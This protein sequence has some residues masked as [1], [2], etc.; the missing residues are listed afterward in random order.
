MPFDWWHADTA[1]YRA[2]WKTMADIRD[3][4]MASQIMHVFDSLSTSGSVRKKALVIVNYRHAFGHR[5]ESPVGKKPNNTGR[6]LFEHYGTRVA[7]VYVNWLALALK[8]P[9]E[10]IALTLIHDGVWD[11]AFHAMKIE[12]RGFDF[13]G[14]P[15]G[16]D[17]FDIWPR[18]NP[19]TYSDV[20]DGMVFW[21]P[22]E[23]H[24]AVVGVPGF[25]D[26]AFANEYLR[27]NIIYNTILGQSTDI[28]IDSLRGDANERKVIPTEGLDSLL[29]K[30]DKWLK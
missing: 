28:T 29:V 19:F 20:F 15:F 23:K 21:Q 26:P 16:R 14:S 2:F 8:P 10:D 13:A 24:R 11:A 4:V 22:L 12:D 17:A 25:I 6:F 30:R 18:K 27:R 9:A 3:S 1:S 7:N 5:F